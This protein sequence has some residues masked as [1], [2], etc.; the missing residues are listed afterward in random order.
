MSFQASSRDRPQQLPGRLDSAA[1]PKISLI[2]CTHNRSQQLTR[3]LESISKAAHGLDDRIELVVVDNGSTD[4]TS[5]VLKAH[6]KSACYSVKLLSEPRRGKGFALNKGLSAT[7]GDIIAFTD[8]DCCLRPDYFREAVR[9]FSQDT[10]PTFRG[11][12][13]LPGDSDDLRFSLITSDEERILAKRDHPCEWLIGCNMIMPRSIFEKVGWFDT[14][15]GPGTAFRA[16]DDTDYIYRV[17]MQDFQVE[18]N[19]AIVIYHFH[20]RKNVDEIKTLSYRYFIANGAFYCKHISGK[21]SSVHFLYW[22]LRCYLRELMGGPKYND[23]FGISW[24]ENLRG[25]A[26]GAFLYM[27]YSL[28]SMLR[29]G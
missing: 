8:D 22:H 21:P 17:M 27:K 20:G 13:A 6:A 18:Y 9:V 4:G 3:T 23:E 26:H 14:R 1:R 11:G 19:P 2:V 5:A 16:A 10:V 25:V 24:G 7:S 12:C 29:S 15:F 28:Q